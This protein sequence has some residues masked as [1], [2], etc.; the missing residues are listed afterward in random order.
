MLGAGVGAAEIRAALGQAAEGLDTLPLLA[1]AMRAG[2]VGCP[3]TAG[4]AAVVEGR[5]SVEAWADGVTAPSGRAQ[6]RRR[7]ALAGR[8]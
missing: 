8:E 1:V 2:R 6:R 4:L 3:A 7:V 5:V